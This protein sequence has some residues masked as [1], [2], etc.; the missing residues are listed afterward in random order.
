MQFSSLHFLAAIVITGVPIAYYSFRGGRW[1]WGQIGPSLVSYRLLIL[2]AAVAVLVALCVCLAYFFSL[3]FDPGFPKGEVVELA[4][5]FLGLTVAYNCGYL[6][7]VFPGRRRVQK[8]QNIFCW[9]LPATLWG[10]A[11][12]AAASFGSTFQPR[13]QLTI[14]VLVGTGLYCLG[15]ALWENFRQSDAF[16]DSEF[17]RLLW[18]LSVAFVGAST[19]IVLLGVAV[20][21]VSL[22]PWAPMFG[23]VLLLVSLVAYLGGFVYVLARDQ[24]SR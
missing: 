16:A 7:S 8:F 19:A 14:F 6:F 18:K 17:V 11:A 20:R 12:P 9:G 3:L 5:M 21:A 23:V 1:V 15:F 4:T 22:S 24:R 13:H 2:L 10:A